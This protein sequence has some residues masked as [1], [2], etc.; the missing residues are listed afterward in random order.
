[1]TKRAL[2]WWLHAFAFIAA[3]TAF[4]FLDFIEIAAVHVTERTFCWRF[5]A[6]PDVAADTAFPL[7]DVITRLGHFF[8]AAGCRF[9]PWLLVL[10]HR[11]AEGP[12]TV[13][14]FGMKDFFCQRAQWFPIEFFV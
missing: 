11:F 12:A 4:P 5:L 10:C 2:G 8:I 6:F 9:F 3:N 1:M 14:I 13:F 7:S